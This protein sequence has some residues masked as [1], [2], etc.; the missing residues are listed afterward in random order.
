M[1][2]IEHERVK[3][4][5]NASAL[6]PLSKHCRSAMQQGGSSSNHHVHT[7]TCLITCFCQLQEL[8]LVREHRCS[9]HAE[10]KERLSEKRQDVEGGHECGGKQEFVVE[11]PKT[12]I[13][14]KAV[15]GLHRTRL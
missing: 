10:H 2:K 7:A 3:S 11:E 15:N 5:G 8:G 14:L 9:S 12:C 4:L 1:A 6:P 13:T